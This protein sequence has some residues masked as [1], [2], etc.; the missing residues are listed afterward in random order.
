M[1]YLLKGFVFGFLAQ[2]LTFYQL[3][4]QMK[5]TFF[6]N[7]TLLIAFM[8]VPISLL[9]MHSVQNFI[10]YGDGQLWPSRILGQAIGL[11]VFTSLSIIL[12]REP[13]TT[14]TVV[15]LLLGICIMIIQLFWK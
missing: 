7:N 4:G 1:S 13:L 5:Y 15:C 8:G 2:V 11:F 6:K 14:K 9:F 12:F 10:K 3:Q